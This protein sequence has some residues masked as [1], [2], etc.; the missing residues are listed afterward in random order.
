M[1]KIM[2]ILSEELAQTMIEYVA[3]QALREAIRE[4]NSD[5]EKVAKRFDL[6][7]EHLRIVLAYLYRDMLPVNIEEVVADAIEKQTNEDS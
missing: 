3:Q 4:Y 7:V 5:F 1:S 6:P 2:K